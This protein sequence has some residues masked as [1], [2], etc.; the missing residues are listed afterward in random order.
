MKYKYE[1]KYNYILKGPFNKKDDMMKIILSDEI[2]H[3][4]GLLSPR[5]KQI[6]FDNNDNFILSIN[7]ANISEPV[8]TI[9]R[10]T[11]IEENVIIF[12]GETSVYPNH[13]DILT[14]PQQI[15]IDILKCLLFRKLIGTN[16]TCARNLILT[17]NNCVSIDDPAL[18]SPDTQFMWKT[19]INNQKLKH[20]Y[21]TC[22]KNNWEHVMEFMDNVLKL[23]DEK[24][25]NDLLNNDQIEFIY[26]QC[27]SLDDPN[28]WKW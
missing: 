4:F 15:Q 19:Q 11:K 24:K 10:T 12:N 14:F 27:Y 13:A 8:E 22:L 7:F 1:T 17:S 16:D 28:K 5:S 25:M 3:R 26:N 20:S 21:I 9:T 6:S 2:K 18:F 23:L